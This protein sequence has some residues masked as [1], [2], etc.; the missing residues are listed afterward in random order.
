MGY[1]EALNHLCVICGKSV[2]PYK[3]GIMTHMKKKHGWTNLQTAR[4][5]SKSQQET[6]KISEIS[7]PHPRKRLTNKAH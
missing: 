7:L 2:S 1:N 3:I 4:L 5:L 6:N